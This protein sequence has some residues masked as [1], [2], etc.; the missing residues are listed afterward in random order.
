MRRAPV[1][2]SRLQGTKTKTMFDVIL[3]LQVKAVKHLK[4]LGD[5]PEV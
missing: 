2:V 1:T 5:S 3:Y 4:E